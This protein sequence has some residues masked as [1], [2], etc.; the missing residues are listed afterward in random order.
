ML[1]SSVNLEPQLS[2]EARHSHPYPKSGAI[3]L[4]PTCEEEPCEEDSSQGGGDRFPAP[5]STIPIAQRLSRSQAGAMLDSKPLGPQSQIRAGTGPACDP[6]LRSLLQGM[7]R[8]ALVLS[9]WVCF[10]FKC[11]QLE[12]RAGGPRMRMRTS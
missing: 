11:M 5:L 12:S 2:I 7:Q 6:Q 4:G 8:E 1:P 10:S 9:R 3:A